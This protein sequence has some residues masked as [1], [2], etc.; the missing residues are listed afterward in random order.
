[1]ATPQP[2]TP[3][4][5]TFTS[6]TKEQGKSYA[7]ARP[8]YHPK[9]YETVLE[10][11]TSTGGQLNTLLDVG[12]GPGITALAL[13]PS[14]SQTIGLDPSEGMITTAR[15]LSNPNTSTSTNT[16]TG[17]TLPHPIRFEISTA[18]DLGHHL[19]PPIP[20]SSIDLITASTAAHWF[21]MSQF[22]VAAS[23]VLKPGGTV[24]LWTTGQI[25]IHPSVPN[26]EALNKALMEI[27]ERDL[28]PFF[29]EGN[30]LARNLYVDLLMPWDLKGELGF[31]KESFVRMEWGTGERDSEEF[32]EGGLLSVDL[33]LLE[34]VMG[35]ASPV[36]RWRERYV[37]DVG[38]ERDVVRRI[39]REIERLL[40]EAGVKEGEEV[41]KGSPK[42]VL[43][44]VKKRV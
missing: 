14:F 26:A 8:S 2:S 6:Y 42:G 20:A 34:R 10:L 5:K 33:D 16:S 44:V 30:W 35:T 9:L 28:Q 31:E 27:E 23:R 3:T 18:E 38:T 43:L 21:N 13:A 29:E 25:G 7:Q 11:H 12:C 39:R 40:R 36:Q 37:E 1:M 24:A 17:D 32:F 22:W 19:T 4:E 15:L 41:V